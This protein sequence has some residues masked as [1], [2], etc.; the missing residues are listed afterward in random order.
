M[1]SGF[2]Y[3][4]SYRDP[5]LTE[6]YD[7]F[8]GLAQQIEHFDADKREMIKYILGT[9][10]TLDQPKT[11]MEQLNHAIGRFYKQLTDADFLSRNAIEILQTTAADI[12]DCADFAAVCRDCE[13]YAA[14]V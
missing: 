11:N 1:R 14:S 2:S 7:I 4:Y 8:K 13:T 9:I 3:F 10:N 5:R 6:T 12:R